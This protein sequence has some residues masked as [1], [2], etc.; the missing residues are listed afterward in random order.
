MSN[1]RKA[2]IGIYLDRATQ[3]QINRWIKSNI[4]RGNRLNPYPKYP[5]H[6][7][8][9]TIKYDIK[10]KDPKKLEGA[11]EKFDKDNIKLNL[12]KI[13]LFHDGDYDVIKVDVDSDDARKL[14]NIVEK[15]INAAK[16][17]NVNNKS[18][19][20]ARTAANPALLIRYMSSWSSSSCSISMQE[21][22]TTKSKT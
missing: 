5:I 6:K 10:D 17:A 18:Q 20:D 15:N 8:H 4:P 2:W 22:L 19:N 11:L 9:L 7:K 1:K 12:G 3:A 21:F 13:N 16:A 14:K